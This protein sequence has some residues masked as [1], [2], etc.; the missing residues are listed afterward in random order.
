MSLL[1]K[2]AMKKTKQNETVFDLK[3][4]IRNYQAKK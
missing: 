4:L 3:L 2:I 1:K